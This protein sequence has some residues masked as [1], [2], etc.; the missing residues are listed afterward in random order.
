MQ[1]CLEIRSMEERHNEIVRNFY[2]ISDEYNVLHPN[3][4]ATGD[5][6]GKGTGHP[7]GAKIILPNCNGKLGYIDY[8]NWDTAI[9][10]HAGNDVDNRARETAL[11][12]SLY[13][14]EKE[15]SAMLIDTSANRAE[16]QYS[17]H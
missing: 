15:Y 4:L 7:G 16:G 9:S 8:S 2:T 14:Q 11:A 5:S 17:V 10:S 12:R 1:S 6:H 3:A 13:N